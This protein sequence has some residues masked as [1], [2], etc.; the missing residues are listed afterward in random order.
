LFHFPKVEIVLP[1]ADPARYARNDG[2]QG[3]QARPKERR[4]NTYTDQLRL[5]LPE[6][7]CEALAR[8]RSNS[9]FRRKRR[10]AICRGRPRLRRARA[11]KRPRKQLQK[12]LSARRPATI[13]GERMP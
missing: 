8:V 10:L 7:R 5:V 11:A 4:L 9:K 12:I 6:I 13:R 1:I 3:R 2:R